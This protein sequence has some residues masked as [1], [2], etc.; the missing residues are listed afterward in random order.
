MRSKT[1]CI[2]VIYGNNAKVN[3]DIFNFYPQQY[4]LLKNPPQHQPSF[5]FSIDHKVYY[6]KK[7]SLSFDFSIKHLYYEYFLYCK[8]EKLKSVELRVLS[9]KLQNFDF[10]DLPGVIVFSNYN[11]SFQQTCNPSYSMFLTLTKQLESEKL[12]K[13]KVSGLNVPFY[14]FWSIDGSQYKGENM[15][16]DTTNWLSIWPRKT[17]QINNRKKQ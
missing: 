17:L 7:F 3:I 15:N 1:F 12:K 4:I 14:T 16:F 13:S 9:T 11:R 5:L 2:V 6:K 8:I 10:L